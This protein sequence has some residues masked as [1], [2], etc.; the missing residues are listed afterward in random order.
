MNQSTRYDDMALQ[1]PSAVVEDLLPLVKSIALR[2]RVKLPDFIELDDLTQA[3]LIGLLN[4]CQSY[5]P[6]QGANFRTYASIRIRGAIL[7]ELRRND[8]LPRSVQTQLGEVSRAI[9]KVE[10][11]EGRTAQDHEVA[12]AMNLSLDEYRELT[13]K[14]SAAR[15]VYLDA[16]PDSADDVPVAATEP[17]AEYSEEEQ[18]A[19]LRSG[20]DML[21]EREKLMMSLYYVEELNIREIA[22]VLEVTEG[23]V[24]QLHGQALARLRSRLGNL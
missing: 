4:A 15:L 16:N 14:L 22:A 3:G 20:I 21:P 1:D 12:E 7:D 5:D 8:W 17:E 18:R 2:I 13:T 6:N 9:A 24:S 11:R 23:R 10:A 19:L